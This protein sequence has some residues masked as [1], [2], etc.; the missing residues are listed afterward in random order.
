MAP[1]ATFPDFEFFLIVIKERDTFGA[2][3]IMVQ[4]FPFGIYGYSPKLPNLMYYTRFP[5]RMVHTILY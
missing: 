1:M 2:I 3:Y 5:A 4:G